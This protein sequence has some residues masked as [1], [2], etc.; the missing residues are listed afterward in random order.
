[1]RTRRSTDAVV[2]VILDSILKGDIQPGDKL[3]SAQRLGAMI[4]TSF[5]S[6]RVV[7]KGLE[8]IGLIEI[9]HAEACS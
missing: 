9:S 6:T 5:V 3:P 8:T 1:M 4:G 7:L 2:E